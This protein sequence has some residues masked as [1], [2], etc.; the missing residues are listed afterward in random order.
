MLRASLKA[1]DDRGECR[2]SRFL[3]SSASFSA[4]RFRTEVFGA[5][6][7]VRPFRRALLAV[8]SSS[9]SLFY[10]LPLSGTSRLYR[11]CS[12]L[13]L[14]ELRLVLEHADDPLLQP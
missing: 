1:A 14:R 12:L 5:L 2:L 13:R 9:G 3:R 8:R 7:A 11:P 6:V 4:R 10:P